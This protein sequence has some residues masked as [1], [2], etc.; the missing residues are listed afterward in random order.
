MVIITSRLGKLLD[1]IGVSIQLLVNNPSPLH[2]LEPQHNLVKL[3]PQPGLP[4][5]RTPSSPPAAIAFFLLR[6]ASFALL[7]P[8]TI[9]F[10]NARRSPTPPST[11]PFPSSTSF[12]PT[13]HVGDN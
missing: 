12:T 3:L 11:F 9:S 6:C 13:M 10:T 1:A 5:S 8:R 7:S 2:D 4:T